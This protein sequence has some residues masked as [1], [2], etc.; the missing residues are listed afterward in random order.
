MPF[1]IPCVAAPAKVPSKAYDRTPSSVR[2]DN[3]VEI[4]VV[5]ENG[6]WKKR[7]E[8]LKGEFKT[9]SKRK[10]NATG[11]ARE[12]KGWDPA[13]SAMSLAIAR[14]RA[15][16][17]ADGGGIVDND[18]FDD[19]K[20]VPRTHE[21]DDRRDTI[22]W[23][24][25]GAKVIVSACD[26]YASYG[27]KQFVG[28]HGVATVDMDRAA[29]LGDGDIASNSFIN[30]GETPF[31]SEFQ[32]AFRSE[33]T[34]SCL[35]GKGKSKGK[36]KFYAASATLRDKPLELWLADTGCGHDLVGSRDAKEAKLKLEVSDSPMKFQ[37]ANGETPGNMVAPFTL[38]ELGE[39]VKPYVLQ[40]TPSVVSIGKRTM[41][42]GYSF[43]WSAGES[44]YFITPQNRVLN[45]EVIGDIPYI[46][47]GS[48]LC[49][50]R[51]AEDSDYY[52]PHGGSHAAPA[53]SS[54]EPVES[55]GVAEEAGEGEVIP[56]PEP[57]APPEADPPPPGGEEGEDIGEE[58]RRNLRMEAKSLHH[59]LTHRPHNPYCDACNRGKMRDRKRFKG[60]F[61]ASR[62]PTKWLELVTVDHLVA[63]EGRME[64][65]TGDRDAIVVK[66]LFSNVKDL[67]P[68]ERKDRDEALEGLKFFF[69]D[70]K[71]V[72]ECY[73]DGSPELRAAL[74]GMS[75]VHDRSRPGKPQNN[76]KIERTNLDVLEG[77]RC[78]LIQAG[79]P[80]CFWPFAAPHY[81]FLGNTSKIDHQGN[82]Y[83]D[84][85]PY[86]VAHGGDELKVMR[87]PF[88]CEVIFIPSK[89]KV[90]DTPKKWEGSGIPGI[91]AGYRMKPGYK[92]GGEYLV[93]SLRELTEI[94]FN[95]E[96]S[97]FPK[98]IRNPH[99]ASVIRLPHGDEIRFPLKAEYDRTNFTIEGLKGKIAKENG[100]DILEAVD[101]PENGGEDEAE[102]SAKSLV[103]S[104]AV[105][106]GS[107]VGDKK[108]TRDRFGDILNEYG[109]KC[110]YDSLGRL[111]RVDD[112]GGRMMK[113][114]SRPPHI[115][116]EMWKK[117]SDRDRKALAE[118]ERKKVKGPTAPIDIEAAER[119]KKLS[120]GK[121]SSS[122][123]GGAPGAP[124][125]ACCQMGIAGI[126]G[127]ESANITEYLDDSEASTGIASPAESIYSESEDDMT[128][129]DAFED[130]I[131]ID[132][133]AVSER[134]S[135]SLTV[136]E[137]F[138]PAM[139]CIK[140]G[141]RSS[142]RH[143]N[144]HLNFR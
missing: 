16:E 7:E 29:A 12:W 123:G 64:G 85:S 5:N 20:G 121:S 107:E 53:A 24:T 42:Q 91:I 111:Y 120:A 129:W 88:G 108:V 141:R 62:A 78:A 84:G 13:R 138:V 43:I 9:K 89:T 125:L 3:T 79:L 6:R 55:D 131:T 135:T 99:V 122:G 69:G 2:F 47:R 116:T 113:N 87:L 136:D 104:T 68:V 37:T 114:S 72:T 80:E 4:T 96:A 112:F 23:T 139:P 95:R 102:T 28:T 44:P 11:Q 70:P 25:V 45:M 31:P 133:L 127:T 65:I 54:D 81:C 59:L 144:R 109:E 94:D 21:N 17:L 41:N 86:R 10:R 8:K 132:E 58:G 76:S 61:A 35:T 71:L 39:V 75:I 46:R 93:W 33:P 130:D 63:Q 38:T 36:W 49:Q 142:R 117:L 97:G 50:P 83:P 124:A 73:S 98:G 56:I 105:E 110:K 101:V 48:I 18:D 40:E 52:V 19:W 15:V 32:T 119:L 1:A 143:L 140:R 134:S 34:K 100:T 30:V 82:V 90:R 57:P 103:D 77:A 22:V 60:A 137:D 74:R 27:R 118:E 66:D 126:Q 92:W 115:P 67:I 51:D 26:G 128:P 14:H 106:N